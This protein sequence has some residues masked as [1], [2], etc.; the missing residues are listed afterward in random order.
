MQK[1]ILRKKTKGFTLVELLVVVGIIAIIASV[2]FVTLEPA[3]RFGDA[4]NSARW[5]EVVSI[6]NAVI[7]Y[8]VDNNGAWPGSPTP[9]QGTTYVIANTQTGGSTCTASSSATTKL[10]LS[11]LVPTYLSELPVD[12]SGTTTAETEYYFERLEGG[13]INIGACQPEN[14]ATIKV[15]R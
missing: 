6:L 15:A 5:S 8:Q 14:S 4:R 11:V 9:V 2:V 10:D 13:I 12:P 7:K 1:Q 3:R